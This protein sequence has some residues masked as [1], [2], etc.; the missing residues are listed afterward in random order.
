MNRTNTKIKAI[1]TRS[2]SPPGEQHLCRYW[3]NLPTTHRHSRLPKS[4]L[5]SE[6][7][8]NPHLQVQFSVID[9]G[10][11]GNIHLERISPHGFIRSSPEAEL[12]KVRER[13]SEERRVGKECRSRWSP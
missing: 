11:R 8:H 13:R 10:Q 5:R 3:K 9:V 4:P 7:L 2:L 1:G 12:P 6:S